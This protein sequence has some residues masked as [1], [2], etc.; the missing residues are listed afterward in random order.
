ME[1]ADAMTSKAVRAANGFLFKARVELFFIPCLLLEEAESLSTV[2]PEDSRKGCEFDVAGFRLIS[3]GKGI[4]GW[5][6][7]TVNG[8]RRQNSINTTATLNLPANARRSKSRRL[9]DT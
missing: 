2:S 8:G 5:L 4:V 7:R 3:F 1:V 6:R 9:P